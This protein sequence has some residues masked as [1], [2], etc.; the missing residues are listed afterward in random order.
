MLEGEWKAVFQGT[1]SHA[2]WGL[3]RRKPDWARAPLRGLGS[4]GPTQNRQLLRD[5]ARERH[6]GGSGFQ[7]ALPLYSF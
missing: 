4:G 5:C 1:A 7:L 6:L 3:S 2:I